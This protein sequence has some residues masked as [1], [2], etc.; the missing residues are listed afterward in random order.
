MTQTAP[1]TR[2]AGAATPAIRKTNPH[3]KDVMTILRQH[4]VPGPRLTGTGPVDARREAV[5]LCTTELGW[6]V[7]VLSPSKVPVANCE[8]CSRPDVHATSAEMEMCPCLSCHGFYAATTDPDR[9]HAMLDRHPGGL[10]A[11]RTGAVS[12]TVVVDVDPPEGLDTMRSLIAGGLL[13]ETRSVHTGSGGW[14]FY[15]RHPG[16]RILSGAGKAGYKVDIKADDAY[17]VLPPSIHPR[18]GRPYAWHWDFPAAPMDDLHPALTAR[19]RPPAAPAR[20]ITPR[21]FDQSSRGRLRGLVQ[22]VLDAPEGNRNGALHWAACKAGELTA[23]GEITEQQAYDALAAA[24][25]QIGLTL[26][27][28]GRDAHHGTVGSGLRKGQRA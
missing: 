2:M 18:T 15:Y 19:L 13:P 25:L 24:G 9:A 21:A 8:T 1:E 22:T 26:S 14:H 12:G 17:V 23:S 5:D 6:P 27:E 4:H 28:I 10:L 7:F 16:G 11:L 20:P 3:L